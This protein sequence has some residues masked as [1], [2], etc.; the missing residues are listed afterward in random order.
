MRNLLSGF[1]VVAMVLAATGEA[2]DWPIYHGD[3]GLRGVSRVSLPDAL[4]VAWRC[5]VGGPV[6]SPPVVS[7]DRIFAAVDQGGLVAVDRQGKRI[8]SVQLPK[9]ANPSGAS[10]ESFSTPLLC[11]S[12][13]VLTGSDQGVLRAFDAVTGAE[14]WQQKIGDDVLGSPNWVPAADGSGAG[15]LVMSRHD[16][17]LKRLVLDTGK[18]VWASDPVSRCDTPPAVGEGVAVFGA[19]DSAVHILAL[20]DGK[21]RGT[22]PL[23]E[24]GPMAGGAAVDGRLAFIGTRDGSVVCLDIPDAKVSWISRCASNEVFTTPAVTSNR[25]VAGSNDGR[26]YCLDRFAGKTIWS[27]KVDGSPSSPVVAGGKVVVAAE[28]TLFLLSLE[29]GRRIWAGQAADSLTSPAVTGDGVIVGTDDGFLIM[30][31]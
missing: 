30:Y 17:V 19:C 14:R 1:V 31:R 22:I 26:V 8:W 20:A 4:S 24:H 7:G 9:S 29:T 12:G 3:A 18:P 15:V 10:Q 5:R 21:S 25:V 2:G 6:V 11:V 27:A 13:L 28:G 16:G 23:G